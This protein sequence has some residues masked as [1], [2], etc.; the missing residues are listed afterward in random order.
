MIDGA[1]AK[2]V[3]GPKSNGFTRRIVD[4]KDA[5]RRTGSRY[6]FRD[7][8]AIEGGRKGIDLQATLIS[9]VGNCRFTGQTEAPDQPCDTSE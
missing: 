4:Q 8:A 2:L 3:L 5:E 9:V 6:V 7:F 1:G